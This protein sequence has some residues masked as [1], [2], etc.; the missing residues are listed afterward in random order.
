MRKTIKGVV[1]SDKMQSTAVVEV[2]TQKIHP[3][4]GRR[5]RRTKRYLANNPENS[6]KTGDQV[7]IAETKPMSRN[8]RWE[9]VSRAD[10]LKKGK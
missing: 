3:I 4:I 7:T 6:F 8:K 5:Y 10:E 9:I 2:A 1:V